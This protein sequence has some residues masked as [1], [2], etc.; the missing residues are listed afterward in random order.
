MPYDTAG[1]S[2]TIRTVQPNGQA[3]RDHQNFPA[4]S[5]GYFQAVH[6]EPG[7]IYF[8]AYNTA[9]NKNAYYVYQNQ[10]VRPT[11]IDP[12]AFNTTYPT[13]LISPNGERVLWT[14]LRDGKNT[15]F[16]GDVA[17]KAKKPLAGLSTY[18]PYGWFS[19]NYLLVSR[20]SSELYVMPAEGLKAN[21]QPLK[22]T[23]YYKPAQTFAGYGHGYGGL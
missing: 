6:Y 7:G 19:D 22:I 10:S 21:R 3:K 23:D 2:D 15:L 17:V 20:N 5:T 9:D 4:G 8:E 11:T 18:A 14:E 13:Y 12:G 16:T 1:K